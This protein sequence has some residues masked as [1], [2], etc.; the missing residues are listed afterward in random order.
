MNNVLNSWE[1]GQGKAKGKCSK[2]MMR[3][4][5]AVQAKVAE[6]HSRGG[7]F[8]KMGGSLVGSSSVNGGSLESW[9][10]L[11]VYLVWP[12]VICEKPQ[13]SYYLDHVGLCA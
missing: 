8:A 12:R 3:L 4:G 10:T 13:L 7:P 1:R 6:G 5:A 11:I 2:A 9:L